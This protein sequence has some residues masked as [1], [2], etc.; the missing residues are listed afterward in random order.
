M[1][2]VAF[3]CGTRGVVGACLAA[4]SRSG[5]SAEAAYRSQTHQPDEVVRGRHKVTREVHPLQTTKACFTERPDRV[6]QTMPILHQRLTH[7]AE[8]GLL[9]RAFAAKAGIGVGPA[10]MRALERFSPWKSTHRLFGLPPSGRSAGGGSSLGRK[11]VRLAAASIS[12]PSTLK[13][14]SLSKSSRLAWRTTSSKNSRLTR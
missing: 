7:V 4:W 12:V 8:L 2:R 6:Q 13:W 14:S 1:R 3:S 11:L 5:S 9:A 10:L